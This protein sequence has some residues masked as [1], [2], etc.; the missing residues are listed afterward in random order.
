MRSDGIMYI[1]MFCT[2]AHYL[3][4]LMGA[5]VVLVAQLMAWSVIIESELGLFHNRL[6]T[7]PPCLLNKT[8]KAHP[9]VLSMREDMRR[10]E[11]ESE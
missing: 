8:N 4:L 7:G 9:L 10:E 3:A 2:P 5:E 1:V 11:S 6:N